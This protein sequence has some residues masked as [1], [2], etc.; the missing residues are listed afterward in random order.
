MRLIA[1]V[2]TPF[3]WVIWVRVAGM[4]LADE[5]STRQLSGTELS[6]ANTPMPMTR[7]KGSSPKNS[8]F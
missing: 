5:G 6:W 7:D 3:Q 2:V 8:L 4:C 1:L